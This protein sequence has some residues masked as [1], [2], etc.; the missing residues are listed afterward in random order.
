MSNLNSCT[1][2]R[3]IIVG[4]SFAGCRL[5]KS[6]NGRQKASQDGVVDVD[7]PPAF[8]RRRSGPKLSR[9]LIERDDLLKELTATFS[10]TT[11]PHAIVI[12]GGPGLGK[13][14]LLNAACYLADEIGLDVVRARG[15]S[16]ETDSAFGVARQLLQSD[17]RSV[18]LTDESLPMGEWTLSPSLDAADMH[19][20]F[21][22]LFADFARR[23]AETPLLVA[24]DDLQWADHESVSWLHYLSRRLHSG[25]IWFVGAATPRVAG[26][27]LR[28]VDSIVAEPSTR[29][30]TL[31]NL[32]QE[33]VA[34]LVGK[35]HRDDRF[36]E[37]C[38]ELTR[39]NPFLLFSLLSYLEHDGAH[40]EITREAAR[41]LAP[42]PVARAILRRLDGL[43]P[44]V[45][46]FLEATAVLG[47]GTD[48]RIAAELSGVDPDNASNIADALA[49]VHIL[50][51]ARPLRFAY[52]LERATVCGEMG[53]ARRA[54]AHAKAARLLEA[55]GAPLNDVAGH[56]FLTEPSG[57]ESAA[58]TLERAARQYAATEQWSVAAPYFA[59]ALAEPPHPD[60]RP[61]LLVAL[62]SAQAAL[63]DSTSMHHLREALELGA[64]PTALAQ[65]A[66]RCVETF[67]EESLSAA[68]VTT[69]NLIAASLSGEEHD[70]RLRLEVAVATRSA[71]PST[72]PMI[73]S[74]FE[75]A[76]V[77]K[78]TGWTR[79]ERLAMAH[80]SYTHSF[81]PA[82]GSASYV[83]AMAEQAVD[84]H[85][86][87]FDDPFSVAVTARA[88]TTLV[89]AGRF[90][91]SQRLARAALAIA[92][93]NNLQ[94]ATAEFSTVLAHS[95]VAQGSLPEAEAESR[96]ALHAA[97]D[98]PWQS[99]P[100]CLAILASSTAILRSQ[101]RRLLPP[102]HRSKNAPGSA[103][104]KGGSMKRFPTSA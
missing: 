2:S 7:H 84:P 9:R 49:E 66:L 55:Q 32:T 41:N 11:P 44:E 95:L 6:D 20:L 13:T 96:R 8:D 4:D 18:A 97:A 45:H 60:H 24:V 65:A 99:R 28:A 70:L 56:L 31:R 48:H 23:A 25:N 29:V 82:R 10:G 37:T 62:A 63:G 101:R 75:S 50:L 3:G 30:F 89:R 27:G 87:S 83:A 46:S 12:E 51:D 77:K 47:D 71:N 86:L 53:H 26:L 34:Q 38:H 17:P 103:C 91:V 19:R 16:R 40:L 43:P 69:F 102:W 90:D 100:M 88:L 73:T 15:S 22:E 85:D 52:P 80:L 21:G 78:G 59:R 36:A 64:D 57:D 14:A 67:T 93:K 94:T 39:G 54:R 81:D 98:R 76:L 35:H 74:H 58:L 61:A 1:W 92:Q 72:V 42:P 68:A 5:S 104:P 33:A 79:P